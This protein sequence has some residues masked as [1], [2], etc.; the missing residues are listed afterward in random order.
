MQS[1]L[2]TNNHYQGEAQRSRVFWLSPKN[3]SDTNAPFHSSRF[4]VVTDCDVY[5]WVKMLH[6]RY[7][8]GNVESAGSRDAYYKCSVAKGLQCAVVGLVEEFARHQKGITR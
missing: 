6:K 1:G 8:N 4:Q 3:N 2:G 7:G 5:E